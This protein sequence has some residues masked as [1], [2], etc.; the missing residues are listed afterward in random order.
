[1]S[2]HRVHSA[3]SSQRLN[4][5][6]PVFV[7]ALFIVGI[8]L[9][10]CRA[11]AADQLGIA[12]FPK[13]NVWNT[14]ITKLP[15]HPRSS[16]YIE[17]IGSTKSLHP[18]FGAGRWE[19]QPLGI[20]INMVGPSTKRVQVE[21]EYADES[22]RVAYPIPENPKV[23]GGIESDGDRHLISFDPANAKLYELFQVSKS[24]KGSWSAGS[25][26]VFDLRSNV[27]RPEGWTSA[28][29]AGLPIMPGLIRHSELASGSIEHALRFTAP[30]TQK[31]FVWPA[32]HFASS[33]SDPNLPPMGIRLRLRS[34]F[35][36]SSFPADCQ[37]ILRC[38][39]KYGMFF[40]DNGSSWFLSGEPDDR[41]NNET[42]HQ[43]SRVTGA[44]F[45]VVDESGLMLRRN[46]AECKQL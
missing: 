32:T 30:R 15:V 41:W 44:D 14:S 16:K 7:A 29:A 35:D 19:G 28:D 23:E 8:F 31:A 36:E 5:H 4:A 18:D 38:L 10:S 37:I 34:N 13:D 45:E 40:A 2:A 11:K 46:S 26:A 33:N 20:P 3:A 42:L 6:L 22:D 12:V 39:K 43:L 27:L 17:S 24:S 1:M 25:G 21:F 9:D